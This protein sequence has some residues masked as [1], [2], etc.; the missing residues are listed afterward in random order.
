MIMHPKDWKKN[1]ED[2]AQYGSKDFITVIEIID[3]LKEI[4]YDI[5]VNHLAYSGGVDSTILLCLMSDIY[6]E[7]NTYT[8]SSREDNKDVCF[9]RIGSDVYKNNHHEFIVKP[10]KKETDKFTGD[11]AVRQLFENVSK[12]TDKIV[13]GDGIDEFMC[14]YNKHKDLTF[15]TYFKFLKELL[16]NH[17]IPLNINSGNVKVFLPYIDDRMVYITKNISLTE[18]V[19]SLARKKIIVDIAKYLNINEEIIYRQKY[20]FVDAFIENNK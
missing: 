7:V 19:D 11:N 17:L 16:P 9:A 3:V 5:N 12:F 1:Y 13:C 15:N 18:K 2:L 8:I 6:D 4:I 14:G 20:G 10:T